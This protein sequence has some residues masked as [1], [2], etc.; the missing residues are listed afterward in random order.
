MPHKAQVHGAGDH[1]APIKRQ[2]SAERGYGHRW[3]V[4]R[5]AFLREHPLCV[6]CLARGKVTAATI[7]DHKVPHRGDT[8]LFW[9][10]NNHQPLCKTDHDI[11]TATID[12]KL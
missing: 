8:Q 7:V 1:D 12:C 6:M 5:I 11:K 10:P 4:Y 2:S 3:R 9:D